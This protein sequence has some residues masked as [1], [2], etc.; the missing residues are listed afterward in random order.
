[1]VELFCTLIWHE[2]GFRT[3]QVSFQSA[4]KAAA[5]PPGKLTTSSLSSGMRS[6]ANA[7]V[8]ATRAKAAAVNFMVVKVRGQKENVKV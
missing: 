8:A 1:M 5:S 6:Q 3:H 7:V 2:L 4:Q